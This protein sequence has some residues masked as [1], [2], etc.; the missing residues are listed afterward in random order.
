MVTIAVILGAT[1]TKRAG[2]LVMLL[3]MAVLAAVAVGD[4][5]R[6]AAITALVS[7]LCVIAWP[8]LDDTKRIGLSRIPMLA[9]AVALACG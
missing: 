5:A 2:T 6:F 1:R 3:S 4:V 8:H 9:A 7:L